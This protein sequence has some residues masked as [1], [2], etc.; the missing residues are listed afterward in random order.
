[1]SLQHWHVFVCL[2]ATCFAIGL[3][4]V[5]CLLSYGEPSKF[6]LLDECSGNT[7]EVSDSSRSHETLFGSTAS[8]HNLRFLSYQRLGNASRLVERYAIFFEGNDE[9]AEIVG[10]AIQASIRNGVSCRVVVTSGQ[11]VAKEGKGDGNFYMILGLPY[12]PDYKRAIGAA[13]RCG[14]EVDSLFWKEGEGASTKALHLRGNLFAC[15]SRMKCSLDDDPE[16]ASHF[17]L[18]E[19]ESSC[20]TRVFALQETL[21]LCLKVAGAL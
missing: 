2:A 9:R 8:T 3:W 15:S 6:F 12:R 21:P 1:M 20:G 7:T 5:P 19:R 18:L 17:Q 4:L 14:G 16:L 13:I 10:L 11:T